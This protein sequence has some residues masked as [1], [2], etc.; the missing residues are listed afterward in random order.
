MNAVE[1][2]LLQ[3]LKIAGPAH[4]AV[5]GGQ[6]SLSYGALAARVAKYAAA[7]RESGVRPG[8][9]VAMV[10]LDTPDIV[11]LHQAAMATGAIA[12]ALSN[13]ASVD[14]LAQILLTVRPHTLVADDEFSETVKKAAAATA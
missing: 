13:R 5:V 1:Y 12:A 14:E 8:D 10:M 2:C 4:P 3:G 6:E 9:R 11:A 7:L